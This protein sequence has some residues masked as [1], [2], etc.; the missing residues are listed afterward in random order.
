MTDFNKLNSVYLKYQQKAGEL[1]GQL[2]SIKRPDYTATDQTP[3]LRF[4]SKRM[5]VERSGPRF[6]QPGYA[7]V[8]YYCIFGDRNTFRS[9]D[10]LF[11]KAGSSTPPVTILNFSPIE[12][13]V[14]FRTGRICKIVNG[15]NED[16]FTNVYFD[17]IG[18]SFPGAELDREV[19]SSLKI[20]STRAVLWKRDFQTTTRNAE[21]LML[22][23]I[24]GLT[25][26]RWLIQQTDATGN[27]VVLFLKRALIE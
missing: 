1:G 19:R 18:E 25:E 27:M 9:G 3:V 8:E 6:A 2:V 5:K 21:G 15:L 17:F 10:M 23:E 22:I 4:N 16:V 26:T 13:C 14:G 11:P 12:E 20:P 24:D 7:D